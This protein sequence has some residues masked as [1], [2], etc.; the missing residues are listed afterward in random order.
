MSAGVR[1]NQRWRADLVAK[2]LSWLKI[3]NADIKY[4]TEASA[5]AMVGDI[6]IF[7]WSR[8]RIVTDII[9]RRTIH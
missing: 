9:K 8:S 6:T 2:L 5:L 4:K 1:E 7:Q 3:K